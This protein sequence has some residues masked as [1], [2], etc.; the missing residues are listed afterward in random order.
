MKKRKKQR[1]SESER[2]FR[3][4]VIS[5]WGNQHRYIYNA[6]AHTSYAIS[7]IARYFMAI[8]RIN[9]LC[10]NANTYDI[11]NQNFSLITDYSMNLR[12]V[13]RLLFMLDTARTKRVYHI[14]PLCGLQASSSEGERFSLCCILII[15]YLHLFTF[16][17]LKFHYIK[18]VL[19][20]LI[21]VCTCS[22]F[23][24]LVCCWAL[25]HPFFLSSLYFNHCVRKWDLFLCL[26]YTNSNISDTLLFGLHKNTISSTAF[27]TFVQENKRNS[28]IN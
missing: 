13:S 16:Y 6:Q 20:V 11:F 19:C 3:I 9:L 5:F 8:E 15:V 25:G 12:K 7:W 23:F 1:E 24:L 26:L 22:D 27:A 2:Y 18:N 4:T 17:P 21:G 14:I 28:V 10:G